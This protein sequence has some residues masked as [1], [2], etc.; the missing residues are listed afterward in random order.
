MN[1]YSNGSTK[2]SGYYKNGLKDGVWI[3][4][5]NNGDWRVGA[6][7]NSV[8]SGDW[9]QYDAKDRLQYIIFYNKKGM[10]EWRKKIRN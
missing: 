9:K 4:R 3:H 2:D 7:K 8:R 1:F 10:E 6:Y 5:D